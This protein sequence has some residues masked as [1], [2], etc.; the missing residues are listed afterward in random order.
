MYMLKIKFII[1]YSI[2]MAS[3]HG[4]PRNSFD[5]TYFRRSYLFYMKLFTSC[6]LV[7]DTAICKFESHVQKYHFNMTRQIRRLLFGDKHCS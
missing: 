3:D 1:F 7:F 2:D 5:G 6:Y 4:R